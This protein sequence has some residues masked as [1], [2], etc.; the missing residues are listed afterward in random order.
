MI[1]I[2]PDEEN[3]G[4]F[5]I[6]DHLFEGIAD[7]AMVRFLAFAKEHCRHWEPKPL[8]KRIVRGEMG[9]CYANARTLVRRSK[10]LLYVEG[11]SRA[12]TSVVKG[13]Y[14]HGWAVDVDGN[15]LDPTWPDGAEYVGIPFRQAALSNVVWTGS[16]INRITI[17]ADDF[18][19]EAVEDFDRWR[20]IRLAVKALKECRV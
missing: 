20:D 19:T 5:P 1:D 16:M 6:L 12:G 9:I 18:L 11:W 3:I 13:W 7:P 17:R 14:K 2:I 10:R 4:I 15:V 8:P